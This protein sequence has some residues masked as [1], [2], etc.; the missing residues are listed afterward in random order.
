[1]LNTAQSGN[2]SIR[3]EIA[4]V[5]FKDLTGPTT[6]IGSAHVSLAQVHADAGNV[7]INAQATKC[8]LIAFASQ[9]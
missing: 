1:M 8:K 6:I 2:F 4:L 7:D 9:L 3:K 5:P